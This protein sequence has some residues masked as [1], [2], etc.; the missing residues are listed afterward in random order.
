MSFVSDAVS[1]IGNAL[2]SIGSGVENTFQQV[3]Q[4]GQNI[5]NNPLPT[6]ETVALNAVGVPYPVAAAAVSAANG[7]S[8]ENIAISAAA[9]Y[10]GG[11]LGS[12]AGDSVAGA[13]PEGGNL[14]GY[15][16]NPTDVA[17]LSSTV[18]QI[19]TSASGPAL[20]TAAKGGNFQDVLNAGLAGGVSGLVSNQLQT[21]GVDIGKL[22]SNLI[23]NAVNNATKAILSG[24]D[25]TSAITNSTVGTLASAGL[26]DL[27]GKVQTEYGEL[28]K[29][30]STLQSINSSFND[31]KSTASDFY[32]NNIQPLVGQAKDLISQINPLSSTI[33][34]GIAQTKALTDQFNVAQNYAK[35]ASD[36]WNQDNVDAIPIDVLNQFSNFNDIAQY[37]TDKATDYSNQINSL[38]DTINSQYAQ[39]QNLNNQYNNVNTTLASNNQTYQGYVSQLNDYAS[40][41]STLADSINTNASNLGTDTAKLSIDLANNVTN[42]IQNDVQKASA[43]LTTPN[44]TQGNL[45]TTTTDTTQNNLP[46]TPTDTTQSALP[47]TNDTTQG[48]LPTSTSDNA[49]NQAL[50]NAFQ[51]PIDTSNNPISAPLASANTTGITSDVPTSTVGNLPTI[52]PLTTTGT[53]NPSVDIGNLQSSQVS[54]TASSTNGSATSSTSNLTPQQQ[55]EKLMQESNMDSATA[56]EISGYTPPESSSSNNTELNDNTNYNLDIVSPLNNTTSNV[57]PLNTAPLSS[58]EQT[59]TENQNVS[60]PPLSSVAQPNTTSTQSTVDLT[61]INNQIN[62]L[63][64]GQNATNTAIANASSQEQSDFANLN[65]QQQIQAKTLIDQGATTQQAIDAVKTNVANLSSNLN[66]VQ[67]GL[68]TSNANIANLANTVSTNQASTN[69]ALSNLSDSQKAIVNQLT[70]QGIDENTAINMV[71]QGLNQTNQNV[72]NIG[73]QVSD[74]SNTVTQNQNTTNSILA[75][76]T[77]QEQSDFAKLNSQQQAQA[78]QI[79]NEGTTLGNAID[80]VQTNLQGQISGLGTQVSNIASNQSMTDARLK[81][82]DANQLS[83]YNEFKQQGLS[84]AEA[85]KG[86]QNTIGNLQGSVQMLGANEGNLQSGLD[87]ANQNISSLGGDVSNLNTGLNNANT[88]IA[89]NTNAIQN[90]GTTVEQNQQTTNDALSSLSSA[91]Q[92]EVANQV[93]MGASLTTAINNVQKGLTASQNQQQAQQASSALASYANQ[94][95]LSVNAPPSIQ[96]TGLQG[97]YMPTKTPDI[98][99]KLTQLYPQLAQVNPKL[100]SKLGITTEKSPLEQVAQNDEQTNNPKLYETSFAPEVTFKE[101]GHVPEFITGHTGYY[102]QG[103]GDGQSDDIKAVLNAGDYVI[104]AE[105]VS[106]LGNGSSE[107]GKAV[108]DKFRTSVKH[109]P[110][111]AE[112]GHV[113]AMIAHEEYIL[114]AGFVTALG[115]GDS[116]EGAKKLDKM[117]EALRHHKRSAPLNKIP[118]PSKSPLE[119]LREGIKMKEKR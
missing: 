55:Y 92:Q 69:T 66:N 94:A 60:N 119:Y 35:A 31:L 101:G 78:I 59:N 77:A 9:A 25:V 10:A 89:S 64:T 4:I 87:T 22:P 112:G 14:G 13:L 39:Y 110:H 18:Q 97:I 90:L 47:A 54:D 24:K 105:S 109:N 75:N 114:P 17:N 62:A 61:P 28:S 40:Q 83:L 70:Q 3:E 15:Q 98:L 74:L 116:D 45:P 42:Q 30:N 96:A 1:S 111:H 12:Y 53:S 104:D 118:P 29:D 16:L 43:P 88:G 117:R 72:S 49:F 19:V 5:I 11:Q 57:Q 36:P 23:S 20:A 52:A 63:Q 73:S 108:L 7:G 21:S 95:P 80:A 68:D 84:D 2:S 38:N 37:Y 106:Q 91:Q 27:A 46:T 115:G 76:S 82:L 93:A 107:A 67:T 6:I 32:N 34:D 26:T 100:L 71:Q 48:A 41:A 44:T 81:T 79:A 50:V 56:S 113:P 8:I 85:F 58:A 103:K 99:K 65:T 51:N 86:V 102:A 33:Q